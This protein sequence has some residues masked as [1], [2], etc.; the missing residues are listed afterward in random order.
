[1]DSGRRAYLME[2]VLRPL[3][4]RFGGREAIAAWDLINEPEWVTFSWRTW[5]FRRAVLPDA[6]GD[7]I[8]E[9]A[10]LVHQCTDHPVTVGLAC[11]ASL[12]LVRGLGVDVYQAHWYD[13]LDSESPLAT[14]VSFWNV[15]GPVLLGEF[16]TKGSQR[17]P[18]EIEAVA[19]SA[20]YR[21]AL[22][23]SLRA[24]DDASDANAAWQWASH[25][26]DVA[27]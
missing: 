18:A 27:V 6:M 19:R 1:M 25:G 8:G 23:W 20:G 2:R 3:L 24:D 11:A 17:R 13:R 14:P 10:S 12:P 21:G 4:S 7:Y 16:P 9:A 5:D 26:P 22:A 15:P